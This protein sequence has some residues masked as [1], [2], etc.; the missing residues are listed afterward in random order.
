MA[1]NA[2]KATPARKVFVAFNYVFCIAIGIICLIPV[3]HILALSFSNKYEVMAGHVTLWPMGFTT[4]NYEIVMR[5]AQFFRS[6]GVTIL[7]SIVGWAVSIVLTVL[8]AYP[9]AQR[10]VT[11]PARKYIV[12]YFMIAMVFNGGMIPTYIVVSEVG[13]INSFW[14]LILPCAIN[15]YNIILM[16]NFIKALPDA[17]QESAFI[18]GA[19]HFTVLFKIILPLCLPS[20][21][22]I[23]L[24]IVMHHW[25]AWFDGSIYIRDETLKPLQT[26]LRSIVIVDSSVE[27]TTIEEMEAQTSAD[28][29]NG[30]KIFLTMLPI[31]CV[32]PFLQKYFAKGIV[33][34][35]VKE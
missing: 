15:T 18:D 31:L 12:V 24:F 1:K 8:A 25:N 6:Y 11:F 2:I 33:R 26:Y 14:A 16:M 9:L 35:S 3:V 5:D 10:Q 23:S 7:R 20:I 34:G 27:L 29:A 28:A 4:E 30:A 19:N 32:Y 22:T 21:A 17:L 13:L